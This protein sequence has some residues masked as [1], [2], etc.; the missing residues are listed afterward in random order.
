MPPERRLTLDQP[1]RYQIIVQGRMPENWKDFFDELT[2]TVNTTADGAVFT[3]LTGQVSDQSSLHGMLR[4]IR[5]LGL[6]LQE[7]KW[8]AETQAL[9]GE[10]SM[11]Q[12]RSF[13]S[14]VNLVCKAVAMG[15]AV[16]A[17]VLNSLK[18]AGPDTLI[19]LLTIGLA[20]LALS[21][22]NKE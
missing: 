10:S 4:R 15:M 22:L 13:K 20:A 2:P 18:I 7:V 5:D 9:Q 19:T 14:M 11:P 12:S 17:I 3:T 1:A 6:P 21:A 16:S 8:L